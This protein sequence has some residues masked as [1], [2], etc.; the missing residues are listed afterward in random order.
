MVCLLLLIVSLSLVLHRHTLLITRGP[1]F[2][3]Y[4]V[5]IKNFLAP[6]VYAG[7]NLGIFKRTHKAEVGSVDRCLGD[8]ES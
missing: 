6:D 4:L 3:Y 8:L 5:F 2:T 7:H 1:C